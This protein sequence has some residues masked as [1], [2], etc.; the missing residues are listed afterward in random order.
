MNFDALRLF[1]AMLVVFAPFGC[2]EGRYTTIDE[3]GEEVELEMNQS[4]ADL[5]VEEEE[6]EEEEEEKEV[7]DLGLAEFEKQLGGIDKACTSCHAS[8]SAAAKVKLEKGKFEAQRDNFAKFLGK[9]C[10]TDEIIAVISA[11]NHPGNSSVSP[12]VT[13]AKV[14]AWVSKEAKCK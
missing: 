13:Q 8:G 7:V 1:A 11:T 2:K 10:L 12:S 5:E 14:D 9:P 6:E 4:S 3:N